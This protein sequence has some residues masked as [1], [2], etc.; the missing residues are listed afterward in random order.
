M[1]EWYLSSTQ[2]ECINN[3]EPEYTW[4]HTITNLAREEH[5]QK[6]KTANL[7]QNEL[8]RPNILTMQN[9]LAK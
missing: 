7:F 6:H 2:R 1:P 4:K 3:L 5:N 9:F 8:V